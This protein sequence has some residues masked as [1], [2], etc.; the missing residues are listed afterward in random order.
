MQRRLPHGPQGGHRP[1]APGDHRHGWPRKG[2]EPIADCRSAAHPEPAGTHLGGSDS[3]LAVHQQH[4]RL[5][6]R[7]QR[8]RPPLSEVHHDTH[9]QVF[10]QESRPFCCEHVYASS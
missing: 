4:R 1:P 6:R 2:N 7:V 5:H 8:R 3:P 10:H 9:L